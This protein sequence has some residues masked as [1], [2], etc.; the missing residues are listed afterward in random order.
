MKYRFFLTI[1]LALSAV[2]L[3][4]SNRP[5]QETEKQ[6][7]ARIQ[8]FVGSW[9]GVGQVRKGSTRGSWIEQSDWKWSFSKKTKRPSLVFESKKAKHIKRG[10]IHAAKGKYQLEIVTSKGENITY[11]GTLTKTGRLVLRRKSSKGSAPARISIRTVAKGK[12]L[13][14]L[15]ERSLGVNFLRLAEVGYTRKGSNFGKGTAYLECVVTGGK[16]TM[17][18]TFKGKTYYVCCSGCRDYFNEDPAKVL[19]EYRAKKKKQ[20]AK[21]AS[22]S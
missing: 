12:R 11:S 7:L 2:L 9:K 1:G 5:K 3:T 6:A 18:V 16:G 22:D 19:A 17:A 8:T 21:K 10:S 4:G 20:K 13:L 14:V 15:Y